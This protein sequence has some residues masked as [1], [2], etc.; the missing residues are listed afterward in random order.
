MVNMKISV[1]LEDSLDK[2]SNATSLNAQPAN[3]V[4]YRLNVVGIP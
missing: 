3:I 1:C 4:I 2:F